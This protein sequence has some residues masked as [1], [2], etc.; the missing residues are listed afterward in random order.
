MQTDPLHEDTMGNIPPAEV[1]DRLQTDSEN[2]VVADIRPKDE[3]HDWPIPGSVNIPVY[4]TVRDDSSTARDQLSNLPVGQSV[5][6]VC[7]AGVISQTAAEMLRDM[8][9]DAAWLDN[10][11]QGWNHL[12]VHAE[13]DPDIDGSGCS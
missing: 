13:V 9:Y 12:H 2:P 5:V 6:T 10:G 3:F 11:L 4:N 7:A 8:G 1:S